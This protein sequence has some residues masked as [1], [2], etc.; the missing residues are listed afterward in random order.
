MSKTR[1]SAVVSTTIV[2]YIFWILVTGQL[3]G[4]IK[5]EPSVE[6]LIAG[7]VVSIGVALFSSRFFIHGKAFYLFN[8]KRLVMLIIYIPVFFWEL[9]KANVDVAL[10]AFKKLPEKSGIVKIPVNLK[11]EYAQAMLANS[12]TLTPGTITMDIVE[13]NGQTYYYVH[14]INVSETDGAKAAEAIKGT[15][16]KWVRRIWE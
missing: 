7:G 10:R 14:W 11:S 4:I 13:E 1:F 12:I 2:C 16:E 9:V 3:A 15:L 6:V 5:G 8:P